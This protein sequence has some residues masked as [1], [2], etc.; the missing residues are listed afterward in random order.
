MGLSD[1]LVILKESEII[2]RYITINS[3]D[4]TLTMFGI[5]FASFVAGIQNPSFIILP[6]IGATIAMGV[7]GMW[8]AYAAESAEIKKSLNELE[9]H[10]LQELDGTGHYRRGKRTS[11]L[12]AVVDGL[13]PMIAA[14]L[15]IMPF[16]LASFSVLEIT[17]AYYIS[18]L[19]VALLL[20]LLGMFL[21]RIAK[22]SVLE[23]GLRMLLAGVAIS[24]IFYMLS[25]FG[26][27][28]I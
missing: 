4:G 19:I 26:A 12:V 6:G 7:S 20:F 8:G 14:L 24:I 16:F 21:G 3:F 25:R 10:L 13:S 2:R 15:I 28:G 27:L 9:K 18:F 5:V 23:N 17:L 22:E 1:F 11:I